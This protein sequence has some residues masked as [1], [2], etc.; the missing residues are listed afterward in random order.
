MAEARGRKR[1]TNEAE[2]KVPVTIWVKAKHVVLA[3]KELAP[4]ALKFKMKA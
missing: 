4:I 2:R 3:K 1:I